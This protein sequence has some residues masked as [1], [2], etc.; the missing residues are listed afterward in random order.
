MTQTKS[1][2]WALVVG[3]VAI[4]IG[5]FAVGMAGQTMMKLNNQVTP[6]SYDWRAVGFWY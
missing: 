5:I 4:I 6:E 1:I 2:N 3:F